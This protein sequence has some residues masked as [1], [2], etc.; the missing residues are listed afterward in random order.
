MIACNDSNTFYVNATSLPDPT[1]VGVNKRDDNNKTVTASNTRLSVILD[2]HRML[3]QLISAPAFTGAVF[4]L[5][6]KHAIADSGATQI[7]IMEGTP[8]VNKQCTTCSLQI[9]LA[10]GHQVMS[11][12]CGLP[13]TLTGHIIPELS[14]ALLFGI[15]VLTEAGCDV[16]FDKMT[17]TVWYNK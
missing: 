6:S 9:L 8:V 16:R 11:T 4:K 15:L 10:N 1:Q 14:L 2:K 13:V 17:C 3:Q 12:H 7:F 5:R